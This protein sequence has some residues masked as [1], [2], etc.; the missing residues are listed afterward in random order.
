MGTSQEEPEA[1][2]IPGKH[3]WSASWETRTEWPFLRY[4]PGVQRNSLQMSL[5]RVAGAAEAMG[6]LFITP[7]AW[8]VH[9]DWL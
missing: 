6:S 3:R 1:A 8:G 9:S 7:M 4:S 2:Q 5:P